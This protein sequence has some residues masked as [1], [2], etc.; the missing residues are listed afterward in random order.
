MPAFGKM[1]SWTTSTRNT[2]ASCTIST[3]VLRKL[4][5]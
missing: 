5:A 2:T 3:I 4:R 1:P